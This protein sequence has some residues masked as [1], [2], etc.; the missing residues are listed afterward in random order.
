MFDSRQRL[1]I[2]KRAQTKYHSAGLW[3]NTVCGHPRPG[4]NTLAAARRRLA[5]EM[6]FECDL[7]FAFG[8]VYRAE[9]SNTLIEHEYDHVFVG[10]FDGEPRP[11]ILEVEEWRWIT[12]PE[13]RDELRDHPEQY[14]YWFRV[15]VNSADFEPAIAYLS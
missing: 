5:E 1:L 8:F 3:S 7:R 4:E 12:M 2:Q 9:V 10:S 15:A 14:S 6:G 13:L 11:E